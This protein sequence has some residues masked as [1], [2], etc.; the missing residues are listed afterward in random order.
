MGRHGV[1]KLTGGWKKAGVALELLPAAMNEGLHTKLYETGEMVVE[2]MV[3]NI[4]KQA[5]DWQ[6]LSRFTVEKKGDDTI[7]VETGWLKD[8]LDV[9]RVATQPNRKRIFIGA[10]PWKTHDPSGMKFSDLM[11][12]LEYGNPDLGIPARPLVRPTWEQVQEEVREELSDAV[13]E[14][15]ERGLI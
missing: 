1:S 15:M 13:E 7:Y 3:E 14:A 2:K 6:P 10:S 9:R 12:L 5:L 8:N 11:I 4:E